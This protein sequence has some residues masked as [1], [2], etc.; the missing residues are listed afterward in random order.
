MAITLRDVAQQSGVSIAAASYVLTGR[1]DQIGKNV[2]KSVLQTARRLGYRPNFAARTVSTGRFN[3]VAILQSTVAVNSN[4]PGLR[5]HAV[6]DALVERQMHLVIA[7]I[8]DEKLKDSNYVP[9][10]LRE[11]MCDGLLVNYQVSVPPHLGD[12]IEHYRL[13][14]FW[15]NSKHPANCVYP[16]EHAAAYDATRR[17]LNLGHRRITFSII[18]ALDHFNVLDQF[19]GCKQPMT[20]AGIDAL[21]HFSVLDRYSG[22]KQA[23]AEVGLEPKLARYEGV[24]LRQI[25]SQLGPVLTGPDAPTAVIGH[26][27][28]AAIVYH[29]AAQQVGLRVPQDL[30][31]I[32]FHGEPQFDVDLPLATVLIPEKAMGIAAVEG[33]LRLIENPTFKLEP[34]VLPSSFV[35]G[36]T[37]G[38]RER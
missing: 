13:P 11:Q 16:D 7:K 32:A 20:E 25:L 29:R 10:M 2:R 8:P 35:E 14:A 34:Q 17:L 23:M 21:D 33:L 37:L 3:T 5:L 1:T 4:L 22:C 38:R 15:V 24:P 9:Q 30:S 28:T 36:E 26:S 18:D 12:L 31:L 6:L 27:P 19:S